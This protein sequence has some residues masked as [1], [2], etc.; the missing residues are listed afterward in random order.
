MHTYIWICTY[1]QV[2]SSI[3]G[4]KEGEDFWNWRQQAAAKSE[5]AG[6]DP[7]SVDSGELTWAGLRVC[8]YVCLCVSVCV[9]FSSSCLDMYTHTYE[10]TRT[11]TVRLSFRIGGKFTY[12]HTYIH[13]YIHRYGEF[14]IQFFN[15]LIELAQPR[16]VCMHVYMYVYM[17]MCSC[18]EALHEH[19]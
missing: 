3:Y 7:R 2:V 6:K 13:T 17:F 1:T 12:M 14:D 15:Q 19:A 18:V 11:Y 9:I 8:M 10:L 5:A 16:Y 4:G